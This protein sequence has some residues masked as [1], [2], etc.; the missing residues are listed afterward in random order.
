[1]PFNESVFSDGEFLVATLTDRPMLHETDFD[2]P[3]ESGAEQ[4]DNIIP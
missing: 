3:S 1:M 4:I 2:E